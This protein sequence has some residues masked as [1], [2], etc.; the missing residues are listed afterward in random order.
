MRVVS[1]VPTFPKLSETFIVRKFLGLLERGVD[2]H[3]VCNRSDRSVWQ[4]FPEVDRAPGSRRRVHR[5]TPVRPRWKPL[6][7]GPIDIARALATNPGS[8]WRYGASSG[9]RLLLDAPLI[10]LNSDIVHFE[11]GALAVGR[12]HLR[13]LLGSSVVVSFRGYDLNFSG[14][15]VDGYY[16]EVW[17]HADALHFLGRDLWNR[18]MARGCPGDKERRLIPPAV[19]LQFWATDRNPSKEVLGTTEH[20]LRILSVGRLEWKKG[21]EHA[22]QAIRHLVDD[23]VVCRFEILGDGS[24]FESLAFARHQLGLEKIVQFEGFVSPDRVRERMKEADVLLHAAVSEGFC[25]GVVEAQAMGLPTVVT[26]ADGLPENVAD[27]ETGC[28]VPRRDAR[29]MAEKLALLAGDADLRFSMSL[30]ARRRAE[31]HFSFD[32]HIDAF[33]DLYTDLCKE[34]ER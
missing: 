16:D 11:F 1:V 14:L 15:D 33:V 23:G 28:V 25:N 2:A 22:L 9:K 7:G 32:R 17:E 12:M 8:V 13:E 6:L 3:V 27:G 26:D 29:R 24:A 30:N 5:V 20:P 21:Y 18:A 34:R 10:R 4:Q 19:D 31:E